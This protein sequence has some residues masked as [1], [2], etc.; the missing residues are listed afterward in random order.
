MYIHFRC[1]VKRRYNGLRQTNVN[2][3]YIGKS[4]VTI[5]IYMARNV[6]RV[7]K[8]IRK[9]I[10]NRSALTKFYCNSFSSTVIIAAP[11]ATMIP[12]SH[13]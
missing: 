1:T 6:G 10:L 9:S 7:K 11:A 4:V 8:V 2:V 13:V 5:S 3:H 12:F